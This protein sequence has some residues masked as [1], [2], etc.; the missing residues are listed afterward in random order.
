[1]TSFNLPWR[2]LAAP[3]QTLVFYMGLNGLETICNQLVAH[4]MGADMPAALIEKGTT[5]RQRVF[6][7]TLADLPQKVRDGG[8]RAPT[9]I[10]V[11]RV[12]SLHGKLHWFGE[13]EEEAANGQ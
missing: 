2:E 5:A 10:I 4:G 1:M 3:G 11:G 7:G 12:V 9:L 13:H 6:V 8:A